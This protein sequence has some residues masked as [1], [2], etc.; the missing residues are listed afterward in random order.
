MSDTEYNDQLKDLFFKQEF[1]PQKWNG[2]VNMFIEGILRVIKETFECD[3]DDHSANLIQSESMKA[4][5]NG[6]KQFIVEELTRME[7]A[8]E[9][10]FKIN[11]RSSSHHA[12]S[13]Y[14]LMLKSMALNQ[15]YTDAT[16][17]SH[18]QSTNPIDHAVKESRIKQEAQ[19]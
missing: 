18:P 13:L 11:L 8:V 2:Q 16:A 17:K 5:K 3:I 10:F 1:D 12:K 4:V 15:M 6:F 9:E 19:P 7:Q 14:E